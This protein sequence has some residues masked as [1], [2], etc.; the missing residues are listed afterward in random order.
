[1][2]VEFAQLLADIIKSSFTVSL[3]S[4]PIPS[5][6]KPASPFLS[7]DVYIFVPSSPS[8][9]NQTFTTL[10]IIPISAPE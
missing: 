9:Q 6:K 8:D 5:S 3:S 1:M 7:L 10:P 4:G 2:L